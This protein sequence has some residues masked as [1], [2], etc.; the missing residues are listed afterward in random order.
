MTIPSDADDLPTQWSE[1]ARPVLSVVTLVVVASAFYLSF[2]GYAGFLTVNFD[3]DQAIQVLMAAD[4]QLPADLYYWGQQ[5][6]GSIVPILGRFLLDHSDL[7]PIRAVSYAQYFILGLGYLGFA[8]LFRT[9][10]ARL[11]FALA[12][13]LP[14]QPFGFLLMLGHPYAAQLGFLGIA[15]ALIARLPRMTGWTQIMLRHL[16]IVGAVVC[17]FLSVWASDFSVIS[18]ALMAGFGMI[19]IGYQL[20]LAPVTRL[21]KQLT[22]KHLTISLIIILTSLELITLLIASRYGIRFIRY[23]KSHATAS[24]DVFSINTLSQTKTMVELVFGTIHRIVTFQNPDFGLNVFG[25][26]ALVF[27]GSASAFLLIYGLVVVLQQWLRRPAPPH[28]DISPWCWFFVCNAVIGTGAILLSSWVYINSIQDGAGKRYFVPIYLMI[29]VA[30]LLFTEGIPQV[31]ARPLWAVLLVVALI[32]SATL[33]ASV[34][35]LEK[36][37]PTIQRLQPLRTLG[38]AGLIGN[39]WASY[40]LCSVNPDQ[41]S[42]TQFDEYGQPYC[43]SQEVPPVRRPSGRCPRC[44]NRVLDAPQIYLVKN[45]WIDEFPAETEQFGECL[46]N[47]G[48][49]FELAGY[50]LAPYRVRRP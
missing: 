4:L 23:A 45:H 35:G 8:C 27:L 50:T 48:E 7:S 6:G 19:G 33:P 46:V 26:S 40:L 17:L 22:S 25:F 15:V 13:F 9:N 24:D 3:S 2:N 18:L 29:W 14:P 31:A 5:R 42:C 37:E 1:A 16:L 12:W 11:L 43:S 34:Y 44:V 10:L 36:F 30:A 28:L 49:P 41:L 32:G 21:S 39:H 20:W 38:T 47:I